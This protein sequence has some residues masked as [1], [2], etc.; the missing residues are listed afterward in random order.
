MDELETASIADVQKLSHTYTNR[1]FP[2][3]WEAD[4]KKS[5]DGPQNSLLFTLCN[6]IE[7]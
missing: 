4:Y 5:S 7:N 1:T 6:M 2:A 3:R